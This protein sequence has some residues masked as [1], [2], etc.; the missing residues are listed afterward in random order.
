MIEPWQVELLN[1]LRRLLEAGEYRAVYEHNGELLD[2]C[3]HGLDLLNQ[4]ELL[5]RI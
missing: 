4:T 3:S 2:V 1:N 5:T